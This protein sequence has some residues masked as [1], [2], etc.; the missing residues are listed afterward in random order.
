MMDQTRYRE[1]PSCSAIDLDKYGGLPKLVREFDQYSAGWS[2][3]LGRSG[4][5]ASQVEKSP[6]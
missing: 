1:L 5:R 2:F 4:R 6:L 3:V